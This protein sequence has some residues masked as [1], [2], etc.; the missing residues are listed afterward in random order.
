MDKFEIISKKDRNTLFIILFCVFLLL[1]MACEK[2]PVCD[3]QAKAEAEKYLNNQSFYN[4]QKFQ[5]GLWSSAFYNLQQKNTEN[6]Y[7]D[8]LSNSNCYE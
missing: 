3:P 6:T 4:L 5:Q 1:L 2:A 7:Q 8:M